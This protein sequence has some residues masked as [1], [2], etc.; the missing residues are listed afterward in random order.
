[1]NLYVMILIKDYLRAHLVFHH[2]YF[3]LE[4]LKVYCCTVSQKIFHYGK[5]KILLT[6]S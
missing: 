3:Y 2:K 5:R 1:M 6:L 4:L